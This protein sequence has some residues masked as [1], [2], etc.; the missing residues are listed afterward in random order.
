VS[1][2]YYKIFCA[3]RKIVLEEIRAQLHLEVHCHLDMEPPAA[4]HPVTPAVNRQLNSSDMQTS[5]GSP[6]VKQHRSSSAST[7]VSSSRRNSPRMRY[8]EYRKSHAVTR[9]H[10]AINSFRVGFRVR[11]IKIDVYFEGKKVG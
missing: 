4:Q 11:G 3:A 8:R 7:T 6:P 2:V 1:Q 9:L 10:P 5:Q